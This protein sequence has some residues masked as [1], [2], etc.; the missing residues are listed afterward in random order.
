MRLIIDTDAGIDDAIALMLALRQ[1]GVRV[2]AITTVCG[3]VALDKVIRNVFTVLDAM[4]ADVPV[5][6]GAAQP[7]VAPWSAESVHGA[8]GLGNYDDRPPTTRRVEAEHA[9]HALVRLANTYPGELTLVALA[10]H[11]NL[12]LATR[13]DPTFPAKIKDFIFMGGTIEGNGNTD[14]IAAEWNIYCDPEAAH[15]TLESFPHSRMLSWETTLLHA[16]SMVQFHELAAHKT[17]S[18][19]FF[20]RINRH[21]LTIMGTALVP[22]G[23]LLADS[24]AMAIALQPSLVTEHQSRYVA[25]ELHGTHSRG[26][27]VIDHRGRLRRTP[28]VDIVTRVDMVQVYAM[29]KA[30]LA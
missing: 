18:G 21:F 2:E 12:A 6:A 23:Y 20:E 13:L 8:D 27:T 7:L 3:N 1:P 19:V 28:N 10:P 17:P 9:A 11:T 24:L 14:N 29:L 22:E 25:V 5:Y 26:Q 15:I 30:M 4:G 16:L